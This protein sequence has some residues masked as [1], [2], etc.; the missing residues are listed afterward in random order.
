MAAQ[1]DGAVVV[2]D[3]SVPAWAATA[4]ATAISERTSF[5]IGLFLAISHDE[6]QDQCAPDPLATKLRWRSPD[7][8]PQQHPEDQY[9]LIFLSQ[10]FLS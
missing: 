3:F 7:F 8:S 1:Q 9:H 5:F 4:N 6:F 2:V 10:I